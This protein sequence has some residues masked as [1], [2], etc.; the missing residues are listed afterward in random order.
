MIPSPGE[1]PNGLG[2][3]LSI[4]MD[5][6]EAEHDFEE[7]LKALASDKRLEILRYLGGDIARVNEIADKLVATLETVLRG[8]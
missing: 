8:L 3:L 6:A 7:I 2:R 4:D 5:S 1:L